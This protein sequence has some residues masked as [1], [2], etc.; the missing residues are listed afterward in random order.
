MNERGRI[1]REVVAKNLK[2]ICFLVRVKHI[3]RM[4][5]LIRELWSV[6]LKDEHMNQTMLKLSTAQEMVT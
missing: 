5:R 3:S 2:S 6:F 4:N 1:L